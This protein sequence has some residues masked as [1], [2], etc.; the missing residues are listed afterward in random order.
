M[1]SSL[2]TSQTRIKIL[3]R[4]FINP[5][6]KAHLRRLESEFGESTNSIRIELNRF[7]NAGLLN[8]LRE[9]NKKIYQANKNHPLYTDIHNIVLKETGIDRVIE[10]VVH[11]IGTLK[12]IYLTGVFA[13]GIDSEIIELILIGNNV[14]R[15]YL[16]RKLL[17]AEKIVKRK[18]KCRIFEPG[19][20]EKDLAGFDSAELLPLWSSYEVEKII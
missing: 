20:S 10:K 5:D 1:L 13:R 9:G 4:F 19:N 3:K 18:V 6:T 2:I 17:Q 16:Y 12:C 11:R 8:S 15:D 7:E 14:D